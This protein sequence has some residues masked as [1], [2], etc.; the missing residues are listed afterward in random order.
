MTCITGGKYREVHALG[1]GAMVNPSLPESITTEAYRL[2]SMSVS[3]NTAKTYR[4]AESILGPA[5]AWL[6]RPIEVPF[7]DL[8]A[9]ALV[10]YMAVVRSLRSTKIGVYFAGFGIL[11]LMKGSNHQT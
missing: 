11:H 4:S 10:V 9:I 3:V 5:S 2:V 7:T 1:Q 8:D 6:G